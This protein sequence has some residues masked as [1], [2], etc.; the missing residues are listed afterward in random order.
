MQHC[1]SPN[2]LG[3]GHNKD[4]DPF[5][6]DQPAASF[7]VKLPGWV[8]LGNGSLHSMVPVPGRASGHG[9]DLLTAGWSCWMWRLVE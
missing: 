8:L 1:A 3:T 9:Q 5:C 2:L 6:A 4:P 7:P